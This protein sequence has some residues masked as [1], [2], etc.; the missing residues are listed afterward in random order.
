MASGLAAVV[1]ALAAFCVGGEEIRLG[2]D[3]LERPGLTD[4]YAVPADLPSG[5][6][7]TLVR[8]EEL[9]GAPLGARAWRVMYRSEDLR[10][11]P[12]VVS[13]IVVVP[14]GIPP[15]GGRIV[16]SWGHP[17][18]GAA[19]QCAPSLGLDPFISVEGLRLLLD[20]GYVVTY[21]DYAGMGVAGPDSYLVGAT[22]GNNVLDAV[23]A[24]RAIPFAAAGDR[25][26]LWGHSQGGQAVLFA[27][28][29]AAAYAPELHIEAVAV[30]APAADLGALLDA[31]LGDIAGVSIG[32]YAFTAYARVYA[33]V[34]PGAS[35]AD[36]LSARAMAV[37]ERM[38]QLCLLTQN[39]QLHALAGPLV[40]DFVTRDP[41]STPPWSRLLQENS[42]GAAPF[43]APLFVAQGLDDT[44][45]RPAD[46]EAF[47]AH[48][49]AQGMDVTLE[50]VPF[51]DHGTIAY[52]SLPALAEFLDGVVGP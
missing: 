46:T 19:R 2:G 40:G 49:R 4:F 7:G 14:I 27:A 20:R 52:S 51:A 25:V 29:R 41:V 30:A 39:A 5:A 45:V 28:E 43:A 36:I 24:A 42:A 11:D 34:I 50:T 33:E 38:S 12:V 3:L 10:G 9:A 21:T 48:E 26:I 23:R 37:V 47:V 16:V 8:S 18:T 22:E 32:S 35:L 15:V 31:D 6:P 1:L 17:T 44:L 13:G